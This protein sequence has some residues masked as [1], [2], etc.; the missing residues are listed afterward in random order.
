[1]YEELAAASRIPLLQ[2][3]VSRVLVERVFDAYFVG[4]PPD[5]AAQ[6]GQLEGF[7]AGCGELSL[8]LWLP[9]QKILIT[10]QASSAESTNQWRSLTLT[11][12]KKDA[13]EALQ[14]GTA[15]VV[16]DVVSRVNALLDSITN[17]T[18]TD[19]RDQGLQA[20]VASAVDL[21]RLLAVQK[22]V[23]KVDMPEVLPHQRVVFDPDTMEDI[24]GEDEDGLADREI[25]CVTFP[26]IVKRGD[27]SGGH[28]QYRNVIAKA[29]VLCSPE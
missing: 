17:T 7:L 20:L 6:I 13:G 15:A 4:L 28:L 24:G 1:M 2:S 8:S 21:S 18:S 11:I 25:C 5:V 3:L 9:R 10:T 19:A 27:E 16:D 14:A 23:F 26:G 22:A 29:K 12:L